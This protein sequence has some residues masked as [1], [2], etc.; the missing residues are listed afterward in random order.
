[1]NWRG[2]KGLIHKSV[3]PSNALFMLWHP[4]HFWWVCRGGILEYQ[5][6]SRGTRRPSPCYHWD[7]RPCL[8]ACTWACGG[9]WKQAEMERNWA[10]F[11]PSASQ[12]RVIHLSPLQHKS[13]ILFDMK[14]IN[15]AVCR[16]AKDTALEMDRK[17]VIWVQA[18]VPLEALTEEF[19]EL[20]HYWSNAGLAA[21]LF[22]VNPFSGNRSMHSGLLY[23][24]KAPIIFTA[25]FYSKLWSI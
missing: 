19:P 15:A 24:S 11:P 23:T 10:L 20:G 14:R 17:N 5:K 21:D 16:G 8:E 13:D 4:I 3:L 7:K 25:Q 22:I 18:L 12:A 9:P 6:P 2:F 1:M